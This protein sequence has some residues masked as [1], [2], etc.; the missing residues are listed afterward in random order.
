MCLAP[1]R[2]VRTSPACSG[3]KAG[4]H[5]PRAASRSGAPFHPKQT[6]REAP[7]ESEPWQRMFEQ[8]FHLRGPPAGSRQIGQLLS[9]DRPW[10]F[11]IMR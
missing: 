5:G 1:I 3:L 4:F 6:G 2:K 8:I 9:E 11:S 10:T 7:A